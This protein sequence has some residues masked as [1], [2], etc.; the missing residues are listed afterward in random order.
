MKG[1]S[2]DLQNRSGDIQIVGMNEGN[3]VLSRRPFRMNRAWR[4]A[5]RNQRTGLFGLEIVDEV[6]SELRTMK[7]LRPRNREMSKW[8]LAVRE[9][10]LSPL[11]N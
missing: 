5:W 8:G 7:P 10:Q 4:V 3:S 6:I 1:Y 9:G 11:W 2:R